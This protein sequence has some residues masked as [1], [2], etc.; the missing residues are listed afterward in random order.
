MRCVTLR[1]VPFD[2]LGL[3]EPVLK[4]RGYKV[5][6]FQAGPRALSEQA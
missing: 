6:C 3:F 4:Q 5:E 1:H 2:D